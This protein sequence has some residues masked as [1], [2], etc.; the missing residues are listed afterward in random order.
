MTQYHHELITIKLINH[1][2][3]K[4]IPDPKYLNNKY[5]SKIF[6]HYYITSHSKVNGPNQSE[7]PILSIKNMDNYKSALSIIE[8]DKI[9]NMILKS[10]Y[11][12]DN[13]E[14]I[15]FLISLLPVINLTLDKNF[16]KKV[17]FYTK[18]CFQ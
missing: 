14:I 9:I 15:Y 7:D 8:P 18:L 1:Y 5:Y 16:I 10:P 3:L 4:L 12:M 11:M 6:Y 13:T 17:K 2:Y